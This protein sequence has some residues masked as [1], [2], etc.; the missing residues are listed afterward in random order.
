[1]ALNKLIGKIDKVVG[2]T[3]IVKVDRKKRDPVYLKS[4]KRQKKFLVDCSKL[5][6]DS[7]NLVEIVEC[8]PISK[9][10]RW[11]VSRVLK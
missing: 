3:A 1:M 11:K 7:G 6:L 4:V 10:K 8:R 2:Q 5:S 9:R